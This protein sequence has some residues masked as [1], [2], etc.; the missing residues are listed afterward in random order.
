ML[1]SSENEF[2]AGEALVQKDDI[3]TKAVGTD[4]EVEIDEFENWK[5]NNPI[6]ELNG[7][8]ARLALGL[9]EVLLT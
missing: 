1:W 3:R 2:I 5:L 6:R 8:P 7:A 9:S 4:D